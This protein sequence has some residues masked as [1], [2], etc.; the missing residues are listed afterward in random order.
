MLTVMLISLAWRKRHVLLPELE[1]RL[2]FVKGFLKYSQ[3]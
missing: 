2:P 1:K 3:G